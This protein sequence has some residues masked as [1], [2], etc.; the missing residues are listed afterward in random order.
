M[1]EFIFEGKKKL[2]YIKIFINKL[3]TYKIRT[4]SNP[5][6]IKLQCKATH[7]TK[8][9]NDMYLLFGKTAGIPNRGTDK[10]GSGGITSRED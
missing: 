8:R 1:S 6:L 10:Y 7:F 2:F 5:C 4:Q 3:M 9:Q